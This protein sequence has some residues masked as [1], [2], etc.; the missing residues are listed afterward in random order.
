MGHFTPAA[1]AGGA[2]GVV[3]EGDRIRAD[4]PGKRPDHLIKEKR[5]LP[6]W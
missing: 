2:I 5:A 4:I 1:P 3:R 6:P